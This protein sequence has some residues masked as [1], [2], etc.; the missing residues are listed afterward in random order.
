L[1][2]IDAIVQAGLPSDGP[3]YLAARARLL[4]SLSVGRFKP[5]QILPAERILAEQFGISIGTLRKAVDT[6][7]NEGLLVRQQGRGTFVA[8]HDRDRLLYYFFHVVNHNGTKAYP[9]TELKSFERSKANAESAEKLS[10]AKGD[11]VFQFRNA[12]D[13]QGR[14]VLI[15]EVEVCANRFTGL[16]QEKLT[17][18]PST[19][20][21]MYQDLFS[22]TVVRT[23]ERLRAVSAPPDIAKLLS[24]D[25][26]ASV[27][28]IRRVAFTYHDE[29]VEWRI[30]YVNT[31]EH[32]YFSDIG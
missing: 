28:M 19:I 9:R 13:L 11:S 2:K 24:L 10:I 1:T 12:H 15:D 17:T 18:R 22:V 4:E 29:P 23:S 32:E 5:G 14:V 31:A 3:L 30:S 7:V 21:R 6:M 8:A 16:T 27:L 25:P 26:D 20:Y